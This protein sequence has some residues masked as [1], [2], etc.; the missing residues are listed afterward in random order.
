[1]TKNLRTRLRYYL[2]SNS[3]SHKTRKLIGCSTEFYREWINFQFDTYMNW[4]NYGL[5]KYWVI[6]HVKPMTKFDF[7][8]DS[9]I[10]ECM[11]WSNLRP[12]E[13]V[14][15]IQKRN[16]YSEKLEQ[17]HNKVITDFLNLHGKNFKNKFTNPSGFVMKIDN[18]QQ[19]S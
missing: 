5:K 6:D 19:S 7:S 14:K 9:Q 13:N 15:N 8:K 16:K 3:K 18:P 10:L 11:H 4:D 12:L 2:Q 17:L 1:M